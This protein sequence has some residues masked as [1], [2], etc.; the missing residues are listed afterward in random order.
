[1]GIRLPRVPF[2]GEGGE[3]GPAWTLNVK[4]DHRGELTNRTGKLSSGVVFH[5][6]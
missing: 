1:M 3:G 4:L 2:S 6:L 5:S